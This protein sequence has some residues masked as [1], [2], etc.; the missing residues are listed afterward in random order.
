[1]KIIASHYA[2][3]ADWITDYTDDYLVYNR[4]TCALPNRID[5]PNIGN[6]DFDRLTYIID[7]YDHLPNCFMLCK[8]NLFKYIT[9]KEYDKVKHNTKYTPLL[10]LN[11]KTY[12]PVCF[13]DERG[14]Y[15]EINNSWYLQTVPAKHFQSYEEFATHF[16]LPNPK[17]LTFAPGGNYIV[18][19]RRI[20]RHSK[21]FY[22]ELRSILEWS[23]LPGE[24]QMVERTYHTLWK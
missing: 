1:M 3:N 19:K 17:Y 8:S 2:G 13:Y 14:M 12:L 4:S 20:L 23:Q 18:T 11:H 15:N 16:G 7:H 10:T 5:V 22:R 9:K 6:A 24:A 21:E